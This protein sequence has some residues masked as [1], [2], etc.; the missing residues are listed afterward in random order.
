[1]KSVI[2]VLFVLLACASAFTTAPVSLNVGRSAASGRGQLSMMR[3]GCKDPKLNRPADQRKAMLRS[4]TTDV[5]RHGRITTTT[6]R[7]KA[8]RKHVDHMVTLAKDGSL[9]ARR[10]ALAWM[11]DKD[12]VHAL[13]ENAG[14][15]Y[16]ERPGGYTRVLRTLNRQ[17][18]NSKMSIIELV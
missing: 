12:L 18:D 13:F 2:A 4:L 14:E 10:Q 3:H 6:A 9:H 16:G 17:G 8:V 1:M 15:R 7:A 11:Y 5:I